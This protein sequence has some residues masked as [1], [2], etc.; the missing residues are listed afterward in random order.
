MVAELQFPRSAWTS[1]SWPGPNATDLA[2]GPGHYVGTAAPGQAGNVAIA[3]HRTTHGAPF[4]RLGHLVKGG[5]IFRTTTSGERLTDVVSGA[6]QAV[7]PGDVAVL[8]LLRRQPDNAHHLHAGVPAAQ[9]PI[10][11]GS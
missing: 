1:T 7:S 4:N 3:G 8:E 6:P 10:V 9:R 5:R 2:K 11:V